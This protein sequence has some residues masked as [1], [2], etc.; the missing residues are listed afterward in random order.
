VVTIVVFTTPTMDNGAM[1]DGTW[2]I[3]NI[4]KHTSNATRI[5]AYNET[6]VCTF[7]ETRKCNK[8]SLENNEK[9]KRC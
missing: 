6:N 3:C 5:C 4:N 8:S 9:R 2:T 7:G 1:G